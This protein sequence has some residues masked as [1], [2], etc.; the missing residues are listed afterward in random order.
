MESLG[1]NGNL[2]NELPLRLATNGTLL[3]T[4]HAYPDETSRVIGEVSPGEYVTV[5]DRM[6]IATFSHRGIVRRATNSLAVG[7]VVFPSV[8]YGDEPFPWRARPPGPD[9]TSYPVRTVPYG[10]MDSVPID[11]NDPYVEWTP[12]APLR[13]N[14]SWVLLEDSEGVRGWVA[15]SALGIDFQEPDEYE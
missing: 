8:L 7:D 10:I 9:E 12:L 2:C 1:C 13:G 15:D 4:I 5:F 14:V 6:H 3:T 11:A